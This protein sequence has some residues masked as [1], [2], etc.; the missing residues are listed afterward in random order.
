LIDI[1]FS[2][3]YPALARLG[4]EKAIAHGRRLSSDCKTLENP[5]SSIIEEEEEFR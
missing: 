5:E 2:S 4:E 1:R 3:S